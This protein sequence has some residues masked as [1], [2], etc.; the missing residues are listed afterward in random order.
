MRKK[1]ITKAYTCLECRKVF[2]KFRFNQR[3]DG[4]WDEIEYNVA[5][6]QCGGIVF[7]AGD[8][9]KAPKSIN[10][11]AWEKLRPLF[12]NGYQFNR[13]FGSPFKSITKLDSKNIQRRNNP[14]LHSLFQLPARKRKWKSKRK[15]ASIILTDQVKIDAIEWTSPHFQLKQFHCINS[16]T[17]AALYW[18]HY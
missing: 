2:K 3:R 6:P 1:S 16:S 17:K 4:S 12:E 13:D 14:G 5:C 10:K 11:K 7:D 8:A 15:G 9:F 18:C